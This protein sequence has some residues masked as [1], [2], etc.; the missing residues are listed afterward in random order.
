[1]KLVTFAAAPGA[2]RAGAVAAGGKIVDLNLAYALYARDVEGEQAFERIAAA[3]VPA[4]MRGIFEGGD[5]SLAAARSALAFV[6]SQ[7]G[8]PTGPNG[9]SV[10]HNA[11]SV[12]IH[13]PI[14]PK[15]FFHTAGNF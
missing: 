11:K 7:D 2:R 6:E 1:M 13:A 8:N 9:E 14:Q 10:V 15:K 4:D 3:R 5:G 12:K